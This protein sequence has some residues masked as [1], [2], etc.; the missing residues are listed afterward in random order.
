M[1]LLGFMDL[2]RKQ[3]QLI[4]RY[5][6]IQDR[7]ERLEA[8]VSRGRRWPAPGPNLCTPENLV[9]GCASRVW[10][11][12]EMQHGCCRFLMEAEAPLVRGL[13][14]MLCELYDGETAED[15]VPFEPNLLGPMDIESLISPQRL[16]GFSEIRRAI[17]E[18]AAATALATRSQVAAQ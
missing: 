17:R 8:L 15:I 4:A 6:L 9:K 5:L 3:Q 7:S 11:V 14:A 18:N 16:H 12:L 10:L 1:P 2:A 13:A